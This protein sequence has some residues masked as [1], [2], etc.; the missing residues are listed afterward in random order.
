MKNE[1][2][3]RFGEGRRPQVKP[4]SLAFVPPVELA[5]FA[6]WFNEHE[7]NYFGAGGHLSRT[8]E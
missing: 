5:A 1:H 3:A 6:I 2:N 8:N 7:N 4:R